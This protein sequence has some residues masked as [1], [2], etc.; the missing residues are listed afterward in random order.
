MDFEQTIQGLEKNK[1]ILLGNRFIKRVNK[2]ITYYGLR[3]QNIKISILIASI[4][5]LSYTAD[6]QEKVYVLNE[7]ES[8]SILH[9]KENGIFKYFYASGGCKGEVIGHYEVDRGKNITFFP[10]KENTEENLEQQR[11]KRKV[12]LEALKKEN[13]DLEIAISDMIPCYPNLN[14]GK[15]ALKKEGVLQRK[16]MECSCWSSKGFHKLKNEF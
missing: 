1:T 14:E 9:L 10:E 2:L 3:F 15:W 7:G 13:N 4:I 5:T 8:S 11:I 6:A 16:N 12:P